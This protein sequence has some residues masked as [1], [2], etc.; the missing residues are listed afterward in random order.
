MAF[1]KEQYTTLGWPF[2][3]SGAATMIFGQWVLTLIGLAV[4][5]KI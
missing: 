1:L 5:L 2:I 3:F 4:T